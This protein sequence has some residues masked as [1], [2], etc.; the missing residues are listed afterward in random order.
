[1]NRCLTEIAVTSEQGCSSRILR[2]V[3]AIFLSKEMLVAFQ[4]KA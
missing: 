2:D 1:M 3:D 4:Y